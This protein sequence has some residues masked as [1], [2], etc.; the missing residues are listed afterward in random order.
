VQ[1]RAREAIGK[2]CREPFFIT[3]ANVGLEQT[4]R[5]GGFRQDLFYPLAVHF[6]LA[7]KLGKP[8]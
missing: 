2:Q 5:E 3:A 1:K 4:V 7:S 6:F 8:T